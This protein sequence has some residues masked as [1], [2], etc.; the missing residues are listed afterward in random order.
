[1]YLKIQQLKS[2]ELKFIKKILLRYLQTAKE[3]NAKNV[4]ILKIERLQVGID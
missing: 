3:K 1:M 4:N 2:P